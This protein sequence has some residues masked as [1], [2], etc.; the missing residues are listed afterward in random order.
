MHQGL[1]KQLGFEVAMN[2]V[3]AGTTDQTSSWIDT[4]NCEGLIF[5]IKFGAITAGAVTS[6]KL[7][8]SQD[9][10]GASAADLEGTAQTVADDDD[11]QVAVIDIF[12]PRERYVAAVV[13]RGTQNAVIDSIICIKYGQKKVPVS[14]DSSHVVGGA[15]ETHSSPAE[16]TA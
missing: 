12:R 8:Q 15:V 13:D 4:A 14:Q 16:G 5:I 2:A 9:S 3:A 11:N 1:A 10:G 6:V 7:Q